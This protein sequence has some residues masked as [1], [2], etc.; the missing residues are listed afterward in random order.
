MAN[1]KRKNAV[2][3]DMYTHLIV[4]IKAILSQGLIEAER[5]LEQQRLKTYWEIGRAIVQAVDDSDGTLELQRQLYEDISRDIQKS[6]GLSLTM[7]T[8][9]RTIQFYDT[10]PEYPDSSTL[11]FTHY[12]SLMRINS[13][14]ERVRLE[15]E[16]E[17]QDLSVF[18]LN[19]RIK[20]LKQKKTQKQKP[21]E[22]LRVVRGEPYIYPVKAVDDSVYIDCGFRVFLRADDDAGGLVIGRVV[23][24]AHYVRIEKQNYQ[25]RPFAAARK[26]QAVYTYAANVVRVIDGDTIEALIDIGFGIKVRD[27]FRLNY[28]DAPERFTQL[29]KESKQFLTKYLAAAPVIIIRTS[30]RGSFSRWL[31]DIFVLPGSDDPYE[32]AAKG[33]YVNQHMLDHGY[34]AGYIAR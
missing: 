20:A 12:K 28:I 18:D 21:S 13:E 30:K 19:L 24:G 27:I 22:K 2:S 1:I 8:L 16:A 17:K 7:D 23:K 29:G 15:R 5:L 25:Y 32:I 3:T 34:A 31:A 4:N 9:R 6:L 26:K 33:M 10:Y 11:T 14:A